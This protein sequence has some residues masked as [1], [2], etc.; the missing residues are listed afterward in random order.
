MSRLFSG[1]PFDKPTPCPKCGLLPSSC[2]CQNLPPK[3]QKSKLENRKS[4][5][6]GLVLTP[7]NA[8]PPADQLAKIK[9]EKRK[10]NRMATVITGL[11]HPAND[12]NQLLTFL[13]SALGAGGS[14]Q[15]RTIELQ[16]D[17]TH[18]LPALL[19][20]QNIPSRTL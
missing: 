5:D 18:K 2:R 19:E 17:Q 15:G 13:K 14:L 1:T 8:R 6:S 16:G 3:N 20:Q 11:E 10:G 9:L 12:L 4:L 7:Q